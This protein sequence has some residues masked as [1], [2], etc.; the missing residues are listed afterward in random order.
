MPSLPFKILL[1]L[2]SYFPLFAILT[3]LSFNKNQIAAY[4]FAFLGAISWSGMELYLWY[5]RNKVNPETIRVSSCKRCDS[6]ILSYIVTYLIPFMVDFSKPPLELAALGIFF[7]MVGF[8][9]VNSNMIH[10]NPML[11]FRGYHL[12][13][14]TLPDG[15]LRSLLSKGKVRQNTEVQ[16]VVIGDDLYI[17]K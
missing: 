13:E 11:S 15:S 12:F 5:V 3:L 4:T 7:V 8:L 2:S 14:V 16:V 17:E 10:I 9:Y 6:E 1:F